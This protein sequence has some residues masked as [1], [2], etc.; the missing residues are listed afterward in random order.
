ME[1]VWKI[2]QLKITTLPF[3]SFIYVTLHLSFLFKD[4]LPMTYARSKLQPPAQWLKSG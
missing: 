4:D 3:G 2:H 1:I